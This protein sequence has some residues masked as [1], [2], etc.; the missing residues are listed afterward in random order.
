MTEIILQ[1]RES[2]LFIYL[3]ILL[4]LFFNSASGI[5]GKL[6][7]SHHQD[8]SFQFFVITSIGC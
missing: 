8:F 5:I 7:S 2:V 3:Y 1:W 4:I 6:K